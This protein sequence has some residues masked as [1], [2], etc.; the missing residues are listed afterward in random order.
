M[1]A[2]LTTAAEFDQWLEADTVDALA[3]QRPLPDDSLRIDPVAWRE[4]LGS[5]HPAVGALGRISNT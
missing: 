3:V 4:L 5:H 2:I 1:P